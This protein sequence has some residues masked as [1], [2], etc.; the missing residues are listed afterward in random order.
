MTFDAGVL[1]VARRDYRRV[2]AIVAAA[3]QRGDVIVIPAPALAQVWRDD[4]DATLGMLLRAVRVEPMDLPLARA[5]GRL[6]GLS[7]ST[8]VV[9]AAV[10]ASAA[11]RRDTVLT[12]DPSDLT[13][14][15]SF[16]ER[17]VRVVAFV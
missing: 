9:D 4:R 17:P 8:D 16:A 6:L 11:R 12:G 14:L 15:A 5:T 7:A 1:I 13:R 2:A 10:V 3:R